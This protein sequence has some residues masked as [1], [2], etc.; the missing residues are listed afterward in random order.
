[1]SRVF[2][3]LLDNA[4]KFT[5]DGG[6]IRLWARLDS[7]S[8]PSTILLGVSDTGPG[9]PTAEHRRVFQKFQQDITSGGRRPGTGLGLPYC[10]LIVEA[11][12]GEIW[13]ESV[14][15]A[16]EG[17]TFVARLPICKPDSLA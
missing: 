12:G 3:N 4:I 11:H 2:H 7:E 8:A 14:G 10:K 13:V 15:S 9:I 16:G 6:T 5:P 1:M 17:S